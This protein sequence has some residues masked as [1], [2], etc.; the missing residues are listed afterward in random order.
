VLVIKDFI[1]TKNPSNTF[2]DNIALNNA[3]GKFFIMSKFNDRFKSKPK[4]ELCQFWSA[5]NS[6]IPAKNKFI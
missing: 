2:G 4:P 6:S 5:V 1:I 3:I